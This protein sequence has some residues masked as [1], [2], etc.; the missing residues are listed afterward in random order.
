MRL[1]NLIVVGIIATLSG[2]SVLAEE[3]TVW[4]SEDDR[5]V[6]VKVDSDGVVVDTDDGVVRHVRHRGFL[7]V[8]LTPLTDELREHFGSGNRGV[9]ISG[10]VEDSAA[11]RA[12]LEAGDIIVEIDGNAVTD[13]GDISRALLD[14]DEGS[15][16]DIRFIRDG[17]EQYVTAIPEIRENGFNRFVIGDLNLERLRDL[18]GLELDDEALQD[19]EQKL[20]IDLERMGGDLEE[21]MDRVRVFFD[22]PEWKERVVSI[23]DCA[24]TQREVEE[25]TKRIRELEKK[26]ADD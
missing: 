2:P 17:V 23:R 14:I 25:L 18:K 7:G 10:I 9:M 22:S 11:E 8:R 21:S 16:I 13:R 4:K 15:V 26:L 24:E 20:E 5:R 6:I 12:G 19:F 3:T 1:K